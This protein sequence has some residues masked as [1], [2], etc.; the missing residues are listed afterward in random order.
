MAVAAG[1]FVGVVSRRLR[2]GGGSVIGGRVAI[3]VCPDVLAR[4]AVGRTSVVITG[5][6]GKTT[7]SH[8]VA[9][10]LS[11]RGPVAHNAAGSNM[12]DGAVTALMEAP[13]ARLCVLEVD[14]LHLGPV[15]DAVRPDVVVLLNLSRD[16]LDRV[17][18]I[19]STARKVAAVLAA[20][21]RAVV[22]A[23]ADD[24]LVVW[25]VGAAA[26]GVW[27]AAGAGW[28]ADTL[29]CPRCGH[30]LSRQPDG[31]RSVSWSCSHCGLRRPDPQWWWEPD[32]PDPH[33][34]DPHQVDAIERTWQEQG[35]V[36][37]RGRQQVGDRGV[38]GFVVHHLGGAPV[39][40]LLGLPGRVNAGNATLALAAA[41]ALGTDPATAATGL[42]AV[43]E[44]AGRYGHLAYRDRQV[45]S[46]LVK[47][48]AG[49]GE[50]LDML[51]ADGPVLLVINAREA[52]GRDVSWFWDVSVEALRGR[53]VAVAGERAAD[54]GVR[55]SYAE[56]PHTTCRDPLAAIEALPA[57]EIDAVA[58]YTAFR[59]LQQSL[60]RPDR[61]RPHPA[62][63]GTTT[64][65]SSPV[66]ARP[67][68]SKATARSGDRGGR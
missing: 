9:A 42:A 30:P 50:A 36:G 26:R 35:G 19:R 54:V 41:A 20:H 39:R 68:P 17:S 51:T 65:G 47:N 11:G 31:G 13:S 43:R 12:P 28:Q 62:G 45:R 59:D 52:D 22:V 1:R 14:E 7:T 38:G 27:V 3:R 53:A 16:Q 56:V 67:S 34:P 25:A 21:P 55:L 46:L 66:T 15:V 33:Q 8:L 40:L 58:N 60:S 32:Q 6:N 63:P 49:W 48:P 5:T 61:T 29:A 44:V 18:E 4:L 37:R 57:G 2:A 64:S 24:P 10:A 23:N